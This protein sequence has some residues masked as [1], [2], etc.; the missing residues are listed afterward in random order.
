MFE[1]EGLKMRAMETG[2]LA[3]ASVAVG[4]VLSAGGAAAQSWYVKGFGGATFPQDDD[5]EIDVRGGGGSADTGLNYDTGYVLGIAGGYMFTPSIAFEL[6][7]AYRNADAEFTEGGPSVGSES[8]A[9][10]ANAIYYFP[11]AGATG[12]WQPYAGAGLG[13]A[14]LNINDVPSADGGDFDSDYNFAYQLIGGVAYS[15]NPNF[16]INGE[17]R[18]FGINDQDLENDLFSFKTPYHTFD[19]LIGA[20]YR[21]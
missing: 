3:A 14:D 16:T 20:T 21:F 17:V 18:F 2:I 4:L 6:E 7:Y 8:N 13:T 5:F 1:R 12:A 10:M 9:F 15:V 11:P 19:L